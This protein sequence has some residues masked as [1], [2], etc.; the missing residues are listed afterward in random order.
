MKNTKLP[1]RHLHDQRII[2]NESSTQL[3]VFTD[4]HSTLKLPN[5]H[6]KLESKSFLAAQISTC[7]VQLMI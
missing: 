5:F 3:S 6:D 7:S 1:A 4:Y 2:A